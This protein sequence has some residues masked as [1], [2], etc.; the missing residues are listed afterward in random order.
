M[1]SSDGDGQNRV[2]V[3]G[4]PFMPGELINQRSLILIGLLFLVPML[5]EQ[6]GVDLS[7]VS[8]VVNVVTGTVIGIIVWLTGNA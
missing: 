8:R 7:I 1:M 4:G 5:G 6:L 2:A 3:R